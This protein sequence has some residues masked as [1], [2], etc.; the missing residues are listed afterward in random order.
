VLPNPVIL[1]QPYSEQVFAGDAT[2]FSVSAEGLNPIT[3]RWLK[4]GT[5]LA[6]D[7]RITGSTTSFLNFANTTMQDSGNYSVV[8]TS[9]DS[10]VTSF[11]V[12]LLTFA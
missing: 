11:I 5:P 4:N 1:S 7:G 8:V 9:P 3:Y 6:D 2:Y 12:A 10:S